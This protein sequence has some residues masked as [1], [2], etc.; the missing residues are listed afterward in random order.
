[1][2]SN[3]NLVD[4]NLFPETETAINPNRLI[5]KKNFFLKV[6]VLILFQ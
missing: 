1:M 4:H 5:G 3:I 2:K 6:K